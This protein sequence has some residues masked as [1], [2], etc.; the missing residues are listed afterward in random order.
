M[1]LEANSVA[2]DHWFAQPCGQE[3]TTEELFSLRLR[4]I[5]KVVIL[6]I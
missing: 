3:V 6:L 5:L 2:I 1:Q 4:E